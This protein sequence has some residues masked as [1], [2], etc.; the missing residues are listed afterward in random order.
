MKLKKIL[1]LILII[2]GIFSF[3]AGFLF[4]FIS[5]LNG[6][7]LAF[8]HIS[9]VLI[10]GLVGIISI[11]L[12]MNITG[13]RNLKRNIGIILI[14]ISVLFS[15]NLFITYYISNIPTGMLMSFF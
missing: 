4:M 10:S 13:N 7:N 8:S 14:I 5:I 9:T 15:I 12:G 11:A 6:G 2:I 3:L 1:G